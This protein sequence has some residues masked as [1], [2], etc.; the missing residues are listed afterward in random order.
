MAAWDAYQSLI[1]KI[2]RR[3][4]MTITGVGTSDYVQRQVLTDEEIWDCLES[5]VD[6]FNI[7]TPT[8]TDFSLS[9]MLSLNRAYE[10]LLIIGAQIYALISLEFYEAG[11]HFAV[12]DDGHSITRDRFSN[13]K[14]IKD[15]LWAMY[16]KQLTIRKQQ[17][18]LS[19]LRIRGSFS[20][21][22]AYPYLAYKGMRAV[23]YSVFSFGRKGMVQ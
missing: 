16:E 20:Q 9:E 8:I 3:C 17:F 21:T 14:A 4:M 6:D 23:R 18:A 2:R 13:Y 10:S 7:W 12:S 15:Q 19:N 22:A 11:M 1:D 5:A